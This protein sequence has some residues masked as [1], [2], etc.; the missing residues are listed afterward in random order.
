[1]HVTYTVITLL[2]INLY[3]TELS[4]HT[5]FISKIEISKIFTPIGYYILNTPIVV[6][7]MSFSSSIVK[8]YRFI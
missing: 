2:S 8:K 1:M 7:S 5:D 3:L 6:F 4:Q